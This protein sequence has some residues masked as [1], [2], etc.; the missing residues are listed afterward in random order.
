MDEKYDSTSNGAVMG[1][2]KFGPDIIEC[3]MIEK[4]F[5]NYKDEII[6]KLGTMPGCTESVIQNVSEL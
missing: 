2:Y 3:V 5:W 6:Q 4:V 1:K